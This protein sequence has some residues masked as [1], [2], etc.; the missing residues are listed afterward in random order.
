MYNKL[1]E[2]VWLN[3]FKDER[4]RLA[5]SD[6]KSISEDYFSQ[7]IDCIVSW[8]DSSVSYHDNAK[9]RKGIAV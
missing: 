9:L 8:D 4:D 5:D 2:I 6:L 1:R 3:I 7:G